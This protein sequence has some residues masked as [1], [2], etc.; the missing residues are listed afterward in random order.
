MFHGPFFTWFTIA[1]GL[2]VL[3]VGSQLFLQRVLTVSP[4]MASNWRERVLLRYQ[5]LA[6]QKCLATFAWVFAWSKLRLDPMFEELPEILKTVAPLR[7]ALD[8]GCGFGVAGCALLEWCEGL[9]IYGID[10]SPMRVRTA[11]FVFGGR[12]KAFVGRAPHFEQSDIPERLDA[13]FVLDVI[14]FLSDA[15]LQLTLKGIRSLLN[16]GGWLV[17]RSIIRPEG[18]GSI[19]WKF[20]IARGRVFGG[21]AFH[22]SNGQIR[23]LLTDAGFQIQSER[24]SGDNPELQWFIAQSPGNSAKPAKPAGSR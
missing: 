21:R 22:R 2:I 23:Q 15:D 4:G 13:V 8:I 10:P 14:H 7:T 17:L 24:I 6:G 18:G 5:E 11:G 16:N 3:I 20:A 19:F 9:T 1:I 12:G